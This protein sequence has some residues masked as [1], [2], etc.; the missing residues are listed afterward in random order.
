[1]AAISLF[2]AFAGPA[3]AGT[4]F[5]PQLP[6]KTLETPHFR[7]NYDAKHEAVAQRA[8]HFAEEAYARIVPLLKTA[9]ARP[10][11]LT[12]IDNEDTANGFSFPYPNPMIYV[13]LTAP[14]Q[15]SLVGKYE[16][17][18]KQLIIHEFTHIVQMETTDGVVSWINQIF[19]RAMYPNLLQPL[20]LIEGLAVTTESTLTNGGRA[21]EGTFDMVL[22]TAALEDRLLSIDQACGFSNL[23]AWPGG[24]STYIYGTYFYQY[25]IKHYG[26]DAPTKIARAHGGMPFLGIDYAFQQ[27]LGKS[28]YA[29]WD[30]FIAYLRARARRQL[31]Q[32]K[33]H[34]LTASEPV[35]TLGYYHRHPGWTPDGKLL[36]IEYGPAS[37][38]RLKQHQGD[39]QPAKSL[40]GKSP[41]GSYTISDGGHLYLSAG[42]EKGQYDTVM[43]V[44]R[45]G[46]K[47]QKID[48]LTFD[49]RASDPAISP[50]G[51]W[52]IAT[53]T[54]SG[55]SNLALFDSGG[56]FREM[57][58][59]HEDGTQY[60]GT[61]W[62][63]DGKQVASSVWQA[64]SRDLFL[65]APGKSAPRPLWRDAAV[66]INPCFSKDG[67]HLYFASDRSDGI[68]NVFA[69]RLKDRKLFQVTNVVGGAIE[70]AP[71]PDGK[72]LAFTS[73]SARGWD[74]HTMPLDPDAWRPV[75]LE[76]ARGRDPYT[77]E[78]TPDLPVPRS[79]ESPTPTSPFPS[80]DYDPLPSL[81]P[82]AWSPVSYIDENFYMAG[83]STFGYDSLMQHSIFANAG[84]SLGG[85]RPYYSLYYQNDQL[86]PTLTMGLSDLPARYGI[87][88]QGKGYDLWQR[89]QGGSLSL[90][91]PGQ[92]MKLHPKWASGQ[93]ITCGYSW[94]GVSEL[95]LRDRGSSQPLQ[96]VPDNL[97]N[98]FGRPSEGR[99][100]SAHV[101]YQFGDN[102]MST[103]A[104]SPE[105]GNV[106]GL[107]YEKATPALGGTVTYDRFSGDWRRYYSLPWNHH[108]L[109]LRGAGG[110]NLGKR[111]G[112]FFLGGTSSSNFL[113]IMDARYIGGVQSAQL[114][115]Y[116]EG[117]IT[118]N[119]MA[120][121]SLEYRFPLLEVQ[122]GL[123][124]LPLFVSRVAGATFVDAGWIGTDRLSSD[125]HMGLGLETRIGLSAASIPT[126]LRLGV[127]RGTHPTDGQTQAYAE[128]GISF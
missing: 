121:G 82:K 108:V 112:N 43:D 16:S 73:Y 4:L 110:I 120:L 36:Y 94:L 66:D 64:G 52:L 91:Y 13:Y 45:Y 62:S 109:A 123:G 55:T 81:A 88:S 98:T 100:T 122:R 79:E 5:D 32:I 58:S 8:A 10:T 14:D 40:F 89:Q 29:I 60:S 128:L 87:S 93:S 17:W 116:R 1:M 2:L 127:A 21:R 23:S 24:E 51:R 83:I 113:N 99:T 19:G 50:D 30:E 70:P 35:T 39:G 77:G 57:L 9:P 38:P 12:L 18:L 85:N 76:D 22:R 28:V 90:T 61:V 86:A 114:R 56:A 71:S 101:R 97:K 78:S 124:A 102:Y 84:W 63:R 106:F 80:H 96:A 46:L 111:D 126:E 75:K 41:F 117:S 33:R 95:G 48:R 42:N 115:G 105:Y 67:Q 25:L 54:D 27:A 53:H 103:Y 34:P 31:E 7:V 3:R 6:W 15:D 74:I 69:Y 26:E 49:K 11:E 59:R 20:F 44:Y 37:R 72:T 119:R 68:F 125:M 47:S 92:V 107:E 118:G 104:I 65:F